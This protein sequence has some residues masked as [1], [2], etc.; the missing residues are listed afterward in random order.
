M[1][2]ER[3]RHWLFPAREVRVLIGN[4]IEHAR[5]TLSPATSGRERSRHDPQGAWHACAQSSK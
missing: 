3:V 2:A 4:P 1:R 5:R